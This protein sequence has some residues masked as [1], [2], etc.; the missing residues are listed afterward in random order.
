MRRRPPCMLVPMF[1]FLFDLDGVIYRDREPMPGAADT[2]AALRAA[3][4]RVLFATNNATRLRAEFVA[5]L[6]EVDVPATVD[7]LATSASA[8]PAYF[9]RLDTPPVTALV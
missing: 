9:R 7:E 1:T 2:V 8:T 4:H 5:R 6:A 3:G